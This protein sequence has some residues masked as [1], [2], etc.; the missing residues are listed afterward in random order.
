MY[1]NLPSPLDGQMQTAVSLLGYTASLVSANGRQ[2]HGRH[3]SS[4]CNYFYFMNI[5]TLFSHDCHY[6]LWLYVRTIFFSTFQQTALFGLKYSI[7]SYNNLTNVF[8]FYHL[9]TNKIQMPLFLS[10]GSSLLVNWH[11]YSSHDHRYQ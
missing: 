11:Y 8:M 5:G 4:Q 10:R 3:Y 6:Y 1:T 9:V 2:S 7:S